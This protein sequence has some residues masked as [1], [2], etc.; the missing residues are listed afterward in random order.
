MRDEQV[1]I[2]ITKKTRDK[3]KKLAE[4]KNLSQITILEYLLTKRIDLDELN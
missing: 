1:L 2:R 4:N 3:I